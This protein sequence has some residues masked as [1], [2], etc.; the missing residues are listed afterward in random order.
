M[1]PITDNSR[2]F[3]NF[4]SAMV[5]VPAYAQ[6]GGGDTNH[7]NLKTAAVQGFADGSAR[8]LP[9][10]DKLATYWSALYAHSGEIEV[11]DQTVDRLKKACAFYGITEDVTKAVN[12]LT[13]KLASREK[14]ASEKE[15]HYALNIKT[16]G[17]NFSCYPTSNEDV[18]MDSVRQVGTDRTL[19][20]LPEYLYKKACE[21]LVSRAKDLGVAAQL[22]ADVLQAGQLCTGNS[23]VA[24]LFLNRRA[25]ETG[26]EG[27]LKLAAAYEEDL[28]KATSPEERYELLDAVIKQACNLDDFSSPGEKYS[29]Y[30]N[31][32]VFNLNVG[33]QV[34]DLEKKA[35]AHFVFGSA[36]VP[37]NILPKVNWDVVEGRMTNAGAEKLA[38]VKELSTEKDSMEK[39]ANISTVL[40][41]MPERDLSVFGNYL[42]NL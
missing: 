41:E 27:Y 32:P 14:V 39:S 34:E 35:A 20:N 17:E 13:E 7:V 42:A 6:L 26:E 29:K 2:S 33:P 15:A 37:T 9:V 25:R 31:S 23:K 10:F 21:G 36:V 1:N 24:K 3:V 38:K 8:Q 19:G 5:T 4:I 40:Q 30:R 11:G 22:P 16:A 12:T 28:P 18:L